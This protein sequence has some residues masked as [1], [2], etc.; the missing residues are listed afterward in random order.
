ML[1]GS[2]WNPSIFDEIN[3]K[4]DKKEDIYVR[5]S[6]TAFFFYMFR[7]FCCLNVT[8]KSILPPILLM[9]ISFIHPLHDAA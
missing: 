4:K 7:V 2:L 3:Q 1:F 5:Q 8:F 9:L 6:Q